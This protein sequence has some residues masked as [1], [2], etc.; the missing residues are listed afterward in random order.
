MTSV[1]TK[2]SRKKIIVIIIMGVFAFVMLYPFLVMVGTSFKPLKETRTAEFHLL[3]DEWQPENYVEAMTRGSW[4]RYFFNSFYITALSVI[5]SLIINSLAGYSFARLN[6]K[7]RNV[8]FM[9]TLI[10]IM[11][12]P[13]VTMLPVYIILKYVPLAGGNNILGQGG[14]GWINTHMG[15]LAPYIAGSFG[16]FLFRQFFLNFPRSLDDASKIDGLNRFQAFIRIYIPLSKPVFASLLILKATHTWNDYTWPL[17]ILL[18]DHLYTVQLALT[19]FRDEFNVDWH[20]LMAAT[21]L[22]VLPLL[23]VFLSAQKHF[24]RG[25]TTSGIKG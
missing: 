5:I 20:L 16:V 22:I 24:I 10:G 19:K 11:V 17:I 13:Q 8:L 2:K 1:K 7:G 9:I 25:I 3:P 21:T 6:F 12:P 23:V 18:K 4:G 14:L 15:L